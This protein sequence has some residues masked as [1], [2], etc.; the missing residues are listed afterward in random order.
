MNLLYSLGELNNDNEMVAMSFKYHDYK[1]IPK[2]CEDLVNHIAKI[3]NNFI[4]FHKVEFD[5]KVVYKGIDNSEFNQL[6]IYVKF[7]GEIR[8]FIDIYVPRLLDGQFFIL[9]NTYYTPCIYIIDYPIIYKRSSEDKKNSIMIQSFHSMTFYFPDSI[10]IFLGN[11]IP[12]HYIF[13][14]FIHDDDVDYE[15]FCLK[16]GLPTARELDI[17]LITYFSKILKQKFT[18]IEDITQF[19]ELL[20]FDPRTTA[21]YSNCYPAFDNKPTLYKILK[22]ALAMVHSDKKMAFTNLRYKRLVFTDILLEPLYV[23]M[24]KFIDS[25]L[26]N[27]YNIKPELE[28]NNLT[29]PVFFVKNT[30]SDPLTNTK[31]G[32]G[33]FGNYRYD[34]HNLYSAILTA[35]CSMIAPKTA[36]GPRDISEIHDSHKNRICPITISS[37]KV[38]DTVSII[39]TCK[40]NEFGCFL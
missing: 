40:I 9:N 34:V 1:N 29:I 10:A 7:E 5:H 25:V 3:T 23:R 36:R 12:M 2:I 16:L 18:S 28:L 35:K 15:H 11:N 38:G 14:L 31:T 27:P 21:L 8:T 13:Q 24:S 39:P 6:I 19:I 17:N 32:S 33:L 20:F 26:K 4:E 37:T 30:S 22:V